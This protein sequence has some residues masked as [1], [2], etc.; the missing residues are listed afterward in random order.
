MS[1]APNTAM[2]VFSRIPSTLVLSKCS[3]KRPVYLKYHVH[4][5]ASTHSKIDEFLS[6]K[7]T[8]PLSV[9][10]LRKLSER[11]ESPFKAVLSQCCKISASVQDTEQ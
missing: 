11:P 1:L 7:L 5:W 3:P 8:H 10:Y 9:Q 4:P 2:L 6:V